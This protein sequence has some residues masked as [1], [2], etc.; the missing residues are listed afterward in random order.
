MKRRTL[1]G[2]LATCVVIAAS[3]LSVSE[4]A[5]AVTP[6]RLAEVAA[7]VAERG[8]LDLTVWDEV[9]IENERLGAYVKKITQK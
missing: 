1:L 6:S 5:G 9:D 7:E 3:T 8:D 4:P 2:H